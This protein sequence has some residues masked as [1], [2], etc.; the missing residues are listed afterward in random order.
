MRLIQ[1][2][3]QRPKTFSL[4]SLQ[5]DKAKPITPPFLPFLGCP[6]DTFPLVGC[7]GI[8]FNFTAT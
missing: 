1:D 8:D 5:E 6:S 4:V 3:L 2:A 7:P